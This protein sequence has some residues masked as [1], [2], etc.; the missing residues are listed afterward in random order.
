MRKRQR[1]NRIE[2]QPVKI[3]RAGFCIILEEYYDRSDAEKK[4]FFLKDILEKY[5][6]LFFAEE[7]V[8]P[9]EYN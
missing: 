5:R 8:S 6:N 1:M 3:L 2:N 9:S 7:I 4:L